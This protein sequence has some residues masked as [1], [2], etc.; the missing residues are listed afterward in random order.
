MNPDLM[1]KFYVVLNPAKAF[2]FDVYA[3]TREHFAVPAVMA[4]RGAAQRI[5]PVFTLT[6]EEAQ[7]LANALWEAGIRPTGGHGSAGEREAMQRH[8]DDMRKLVFERE[9]KP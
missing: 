7:T 9:P 5:D 8:L 2:D 3:A 4:Q 1:L 6:Q